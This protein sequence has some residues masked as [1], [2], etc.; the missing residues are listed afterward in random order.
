MTAWLVVLLAD[1]KELRK[2]QHEGEGFFKKILQFAANVRVVVK[3]VGA[4]SLFLL[5]ASSSPI[6]RVSQAT[7]DLP[8]QVVKPWRCNL[9]FSFVSE[10]NVIANKSCFTGRSS[11][12]ERLTVEFWREADILSKL[13]HP[14]VV[15][16][17]GV[18]QHGP[19]GSMATVAEYM[20]DGSHRHVYLDRRKR[21]IIAMDAAFGMEYLHSKNIVH[22]DLKCDNLLVN[23]KDPLRPIR[24][25]GDFGL[26]K[27]KRN[28][29]VTGV[30]GTHYL[31]WHQ[32]LNGR[33]NKV[34]E[35]VDVF[36]ISIVLWEILIMCNA[37][38]KHVGSYLVKTLKV[39]TSI[40][41]LL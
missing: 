41:P 16:F 29:L 17:Y 12:Q 8:S 9:T 30:R 13:H 6:P 32:L 36:S 31:E 39:A 24:K 20:V 40:P 38:T 27:I 23:L 26:S 5:N 19:G 35:K 15:A 33:S 4:A 37:N 25:V 22:F 1:Q 2:L 7:M 11:E 34:S 28:T 18:V 14:N 10:S 3:V 21:L